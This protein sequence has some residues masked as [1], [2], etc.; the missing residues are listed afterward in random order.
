[1]LGCRHVPPKPPNR[2]AAF[3][4][5]PK[6]AAGFLA[7]V[8]LACTIGT[9]VAYQSAVALRDHGQRAIGSV[10]EVHEERRDD[11]VVLRF[12]DGTGREVTAEVGNYFWDPQPQVGDRTELVYD[13]EDPSGN[14]ADV[15]TGP[16]FFSVWALALGAVLAGALVWPT[17][18][19]RLDWNKFR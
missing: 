4:N 19:G 9:V 6:V 2:F 3:A 12:Q 10:L 14:V 11:Y 18:T 17:W 16:D 7:A 1:M 15:R 13:P 8:A 5:S